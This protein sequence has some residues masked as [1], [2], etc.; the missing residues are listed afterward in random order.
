M[1]DSPT[2]G[3]ATPVVGARP[4][5]EQAGGMAGAPMPSTAPPDAQ[6]DVSRASATRVVPGRSSSESTVQLASLMPRRI[7][8]HGEVELAARNLSAA[9]EE[10][11][12]LVRARGGYVA[13][14]D[15]GGSPGAP[16][17][18]RWEVRVPVDQFD[19]FM[20]AVA[21]LGELQRIHTDSQ[22]VSEEFYDLEARLA[23]KRVEERRLLKHLQRST[24]R[25][26]DIL[27]VEREISRVREEIEQMQGRLR[28]LAHQTALS[29]VTIT[30]HE[31]K[32]YVPTGSGGFLGEIARTFRESAELLRDAGKGV[33][34]FLVGLG[35]WLVT[36]GLVGTPIWL[37][38]RRRSKSKGPGA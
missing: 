18:G 34:L 38:A 28:F 26:S 7:I 13:E 1:N 32:D 37:R 22:D 19:A 27:D 23:N 17:Q 3:K 8:Y 14:S 24:S 31:I 36:L 6:D 9:E 30:I 29:T 12:R 5:G 33:V 21:K 20:A 10:M 35:P 4:F 11:V 16:R 25:L 15:T 2:E